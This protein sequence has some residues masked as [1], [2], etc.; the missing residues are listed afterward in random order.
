MVI[1][2]LHEEDNR[3]TDLVYTIDA[4][5]DIIKD[6]RFDVQKETRGSLIFSHLQDIDQGAEDYSEPA[7]V[8]EPQIALRES[9]GMLWLVSL[10][11]GNLGK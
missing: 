6:I 8:H 11:Q 5:N 9:P 10:A 4:E 7:V 1:T 3:K 2:L